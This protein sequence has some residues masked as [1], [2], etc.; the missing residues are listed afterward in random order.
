VAPASGTI[1]R[2]PI[3][4]A[5]DSRET[6]FTQRYSPITMKGAAIIRSGA[7]VLPSLKNSQDGS[8]KFQY[9]AARVP[10]VFRLKNA[11]IPSIGLRRCAA[12]T[13]HRPN[14]S[15]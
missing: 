14:V 7:G 4:V 6:S 13:N 15:A 1:A 10:S 3:T 5:A 11:S 2:A 9:K 8:Q 12:K